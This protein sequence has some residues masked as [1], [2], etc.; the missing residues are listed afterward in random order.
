MNQSKTQNGYEINATNQSCRRKS[1][2]H[3]SANHGNTSEQP[4]G[5]FV[6]S[7]QSFQGTEAQDQL[8]MNDSRN[9]SSHAASRKSRVKDRR[10]ST[11]TS[12]AGPSVKEAAGRTVLEV[13][14]DPMN[15][16]DSE[17]ANQYRERNNESLNLAGHDII[18][19]PHL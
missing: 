13:H 14:I 19:T 16:V 8:Q 11:G 7:I 4:V 10:K 9:R 17:N 2:E 12:T 5:L 6:K 15:F 3:G 18:R 1:S